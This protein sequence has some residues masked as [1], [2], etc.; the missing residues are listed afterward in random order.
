LTGTDVGEDSK[1]ETSRFALAGKPLE[2]W[3][4]Y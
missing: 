1:T 4:W 2:K 3:A